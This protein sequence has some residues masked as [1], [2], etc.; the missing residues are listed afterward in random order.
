MT[1]CI[2]RKPKRRVRLNHWLAVTTV[3]LGA[4]LCLELQAGLK[5]DLQTVEGSTL[6]EQLQDP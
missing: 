1:R 3:M 2:F 4:A 6:L 5:P